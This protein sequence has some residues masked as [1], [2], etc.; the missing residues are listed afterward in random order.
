MYLGRLLYIALLRSSL[1][2]GAVSIWIVD[3]LL[4]LIV[5]ILYDDSV[6]GILNFTTF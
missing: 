2:V 4:L 1:A 5:G 6:D 3:E